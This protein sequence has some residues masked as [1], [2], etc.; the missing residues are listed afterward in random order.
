M[1]RFPEETRKQLFDGC[2]TFYLPKSDNIQPKSFQSIFIVQV[3]HIKEL[4]ADISMSISRMNC[5]EY[6]T[7]YFISN[8]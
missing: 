3:L 1:S 2:Y 4:Y 8:F 5:A 7:S 6:A